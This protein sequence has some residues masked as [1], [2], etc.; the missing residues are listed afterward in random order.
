MRL[1]P[2]PADRRPGRRSRLRRRW[3]AAVG[4]IAR[5]ARGA[6]QCLSGQLQGRLRRRRPRLRGRSDQH[7]RCLRLRAGN[8]ADRP[9]EPLRGLPALQR[10][11]QRRPLRRQQGRAGDLRLRPF[12][13]VRRTAAQPCRR[14]A[15]EDAQ[16]EYRASRNSR[17]SSQTTSVSRSCEAMSPVIRRH[18]SR[19]AALRR[20]SP[21]R[22]SGPTGLVPSALS[23]G[24]STMA[25]DQVEDQRVERGVAREGPAADRQRIGRGEVDGSR[26]VGAR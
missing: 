16:A 21:Q 11:E 8:Q 25:M 1:G 2:A 5:G 24:V 18:A 12:R 7:P 15:S 14:D 4:P 10:Q 23:T 20:N 22:R 9:A 6:H 26:H 13:P 17:R 19:F 3:R